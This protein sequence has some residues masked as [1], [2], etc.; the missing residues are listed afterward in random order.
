[1]AWAP[2]S[3]PG[4]ATRATARAR[5]HLEGLVRAMLAER[6]ARALASHV[7]DPA[8]DVAERRKDPWSIAE[9]LVARSGTL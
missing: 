8:V 5:A 4:A 6:A 1:M 9:E 2:W 7:T 3:G